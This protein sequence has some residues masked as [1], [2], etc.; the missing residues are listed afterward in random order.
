MFLSLQL[1]MVLFLLVVIIQKN[2]KSLSC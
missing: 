1:K 2:W